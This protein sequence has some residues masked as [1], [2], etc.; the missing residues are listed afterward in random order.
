MV[1]SHFH[2]GV[3][4]PDVLTLPDEKGRHCLDKTAEVDVYEYESA[5]RLK[6]LA[7]IGSDDLETFDWALSSRH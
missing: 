4:S 3:I 2:S 5:C 1:S 7:V 6:W